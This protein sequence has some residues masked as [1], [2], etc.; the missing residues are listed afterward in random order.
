[1]LQYLQTLLFV[2]G[3]KAVAT[4]GQGS[5][6]ISLYSVDTGMLVSQGLIGYDS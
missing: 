6:K 4:P 2:D 1:M 3:G 5:R